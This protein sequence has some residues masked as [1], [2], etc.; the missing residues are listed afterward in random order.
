MILL[1]LDWGGLIAWVERV[2]GAL[3]EHRLYALFDFAAHVAL[4]VRRR[5][6]VLDHVRIEDAD[7]DVVDAEKLWV[8][9]QDVLKARWE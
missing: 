2:K 6:Q 3:L 8:A 4:D 7:V 9:D 1:I 5:A